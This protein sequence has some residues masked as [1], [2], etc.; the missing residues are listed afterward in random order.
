MIFEERSDAIE[1]DVPN[2]MTTNVVV[3]SKL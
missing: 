3:H 2:I 1:I